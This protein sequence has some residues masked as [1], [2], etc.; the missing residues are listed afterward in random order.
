[1]QYVKEVVVEREAEQNQ[2]GGASQ[3]TTTPKIATV[4]TLCFM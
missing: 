4:S 2:S 3:E 1:M